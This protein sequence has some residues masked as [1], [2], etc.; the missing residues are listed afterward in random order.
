VTEIT[1]GSSAGLNPSTPWLALCQSMMRPTKGE[2]SVHPASAQA[3]AWAIE[4]MRVKLHVIPS[5]SRISAAL[6]PSHY[7]MIAIQLLVIVRVIKVSFG[8]HRMLVSKHFLTLTVAATLTKIRD[9]SMPTSL[10]SSM[11]RRALAIVPSVSNDKRASTSV[12]TYPGTILV[13]SAPKLTASLSF[14][15]SKC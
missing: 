4:K 9:L 7:R 13:I 8:K 1:P 12:D 15:K 5:F 11:I 2:I 6:I 10:Y 3:T 14:Y